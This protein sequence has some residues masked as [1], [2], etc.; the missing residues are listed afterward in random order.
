MSRT[1]ATLS[2]PSQAGRGRKTLLWVAGILGVVL[3]IIAAL[4]IFMNMRM[5]SMPPDLDFSTSLPSDAGLFQV[6]YTPKA[7]IRANQ[8]H[9]WVLHIETPEGEPVEGAVITV[10]GDMPQH[11]HGLPTRPQVT[12]SLGNGDYQVDGLKFHMQGWWIVEFE[13]QAEGQSDTI[14]FNLLLDK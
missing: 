5:N 9:T 8:I 6:S 11:G 3:L 10:D 14:T 2:E 1:S 4:F 7:E 13:I 12:G